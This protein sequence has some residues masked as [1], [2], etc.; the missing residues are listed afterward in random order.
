MATKTGLNV[1][2]DKVADVAAGISM[3]VGTRVMVGVPAEK[4]ERK[5]GEPITNAALAYIHE[6]G[7]PEANIPARPFLMPGIEAEK[8]A[9]TSGLKVAGQAALDGKPGTV[10]RAFHAV[11]LKGQAA[12]RKKITDGPFAPLADSTVKARARRGRKGA[13]Q[14]LANRRSGQAPSADLVKPLIDR[15]ELRNSI[16]YVIRKA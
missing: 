15:G 3:L 16:S 6:H 4:A 7:A 13:K 1:L 5:D 8:A 14:E 9:I 11:G 12:I 10:D 2:I